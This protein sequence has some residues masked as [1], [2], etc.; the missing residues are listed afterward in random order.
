MA[1]RYA[2][3]ATRE[4]CESVI[5]HV[6]SGLA[7]DDAEFRRRAEAG[8]GELGV[9]SID[10][11]TTL[12]HSEHTPPPELAEKFPRLGAWI[13]ARQFAI[14]EMLYHFG[15]P[16]LPTLY[17]IAFGNYDWTQGNAIEVLCR[18]AAEGVATDDF[19]TEMSRE[20]PNI[21]D[22]AKLYAIGPLL[23]QAQSNQPLAELLARLQNVVE[24]FNEAVR[25]LQGDELA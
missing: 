24:G 5:R 15:E 20:F 4:H 25:E 10:L 11:L 9:N 18:L 17:G 13:A 22:E 16:A 6:A 12:F 2:T 1:L 21:R 19:V 14:F 3:M 23:K 8:A 7:E